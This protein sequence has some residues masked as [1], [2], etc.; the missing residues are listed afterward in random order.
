MTIQGML[1]NMTVT[2]LDTAVAGYT[3]LEQATSSRI[4]TVLDPAGNRI[5]F[6]GP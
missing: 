1:A 6:T 5:V 4:L 2:D 3:K